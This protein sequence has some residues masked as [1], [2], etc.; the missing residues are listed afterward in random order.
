[1]LNYILNKLSGYLGFPEEIKGAQRC[2]TYL[3]RWDIAL[4]LNRSYCIYLHKFVGDDWALYLHDH[5]KRF[6]SIGLSGEYFEHREDGTIKHY[7][8]PWIRS[9]PAEHKHRLTGPTKENPCWTVVITG[10]PTR[11][12]GFWV[13]GLFVNWRKYVD[14]NNYIAHKSCE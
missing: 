9:F 6:T 11:S 7:K 8:A 3:Y 4:F 2:P 10:K 12:W 5:P 1:M 13:N 14:V